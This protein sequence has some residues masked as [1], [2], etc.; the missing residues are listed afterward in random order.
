MRDAFLLDLRHSI[1]LL[2][3]NPA[4][5]TVVVLTLALGIGANA[6][7]FSVVESILL[8]PLP[9]RDS[10]KL[11]SM[12][13]TQGGERGNT[14]YP[15]FREIRDHNRSFEAIAAY[16]RRAVNVT[17]KQD[18]ERL[19]A[20]VVSP[21]FLSVLGIQPTLGRDFLA[22]EAELGASPVVIISD[23]MWRRSLVG[24]PHIIGRDLRL[25][26]QPRTI[27]GVLPP[28]FWF[29]DI[30]DQ[31]IVPL[32]VAPG[33]DNR[34]NHFLNMIGRLRSDVSREAAAADLASISRGITEKTGANKGVGFALKS[35][36][37]ELTGNVRIAVLVLMGA[38]GFVLLIAC[39]N[40]ASL[41]LARTV[42]RQ[43][44]S[45]IR[46]ALGATRGV[47]LRQFLTESIMLSFL[48][49]TLGM[50]GAYF[51][52]RLLRSVSVS[53]LP[54]ASQIHIDSR[55]LLFGLGTSLLTGIAFGI[56]PIWRSSK[57]NVNEALRVSGENS[58]ERGRW[59]GTRAVLVVA[60]VALALVLV[61]GAGLMIKSLH[62][63]RSVD[64]G[65]DDR[66]VLIFNV[67]LPQEKYIDPAL[68]RDYPFP[69]ATLKANLF[70]QQA[71]D[72]IG[73]I[74]GVVAVGSTS[75]LPVS[76]ISW[77]KVVTFYDRPLP[78][79]VEQ[80]PPIE[81]RPVGGDY[82]RAL[83]IRL[84][85]GRPF[86]AHD[87][88]D[89]QLVAI[90]NQ[91]LVR[92][93][94]KGE[95]PIGKQLSVNPPIEL[96]PRS[97]VQRDYPREQQKFTIVGVV[98]NAR[99]S[100]LQTEA[101]PMVYAPYA[102]NAEGTSSMWFAVHTDRDPLSVVGAVR[103]EMGDLDKELPLGPMATMED[104]VSS[105]IGRPRIE[106][107][108]LTAFGGLALLLAS[109]GVYG[110]MSYSVARRTREIGIRMALG[111]RLID[112]MHMVIHQGIVLIAVGL[113]LGFGG[114]LALM[115]VMKSMVFGIRATDPG[116]L[117]ATCV[118]LGVA[119]LMA[120]YFPAR[121]AMRID[122]QRALRNE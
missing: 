104:V 75:T 66:N 92:R 115:Q 25:D 28:N 106:M 90:V 113:A 26:G 31:L 62:L 64:S 2:R 10:G 88:L 102:Q 38:V 63:L 24:D 4:F 20:L 45:A 8:R 23:G 84:I 73:Q 19:R 76:G 56:I 93:Y 72:R 57:E 27:V 101:G 109:V 94:M 52:A 61:A 80:L 119:G 79:S 39:S 103:R 122:P 40:L 95:N 121:R 1:R 18:P 83:G 37:E 5:T 53:T 21:E 6:A 46:A 85:S 59:Y 30:T 112:V 96:L 117:V 100:S 3:K 60:E 44:E 35:L 50:F 111:A 49:G 99:Y 47:L 12:W 74:P 70:L 82:F 118:V 41:L 58:G 114:A 77:D 65:F 48:G 55:V 97:V 89:S 71:V 17:G 22:K 13:T 43:Q 87:N 34:G 98:G 107:F 15:D 32:K 69:G 68:I 54:R 81:Y 33:S 78:S 11:V 110:L 7:M 51:V 91:E 29:M 86:N 16:T 108:V 67:N 120:S 36:Q 116:V 9:F 42:A 14:A 105:Q